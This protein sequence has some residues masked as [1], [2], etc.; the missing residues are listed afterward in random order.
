MDSTCLPSGASES[1]EA[2]WQA[3]SIHGRAAGRPARASSAAAVRS[4]MVK[5]MSMAPC[6]GSSP[7]Q[8]V[9]SGRPSSSTMTLTTGPG[10]AP[11]LRARRPGQRGGAQRVGVGEHARG[12][13][14]LAALQHHAD[15]GAVLDQHALDGALQADPR[16][17]GLGRRAQRAGHR[18]HARRGRSPRR[19]PPRPPGPGRG[20]SRRRRCPGPR[21]RPACRSGPGRRTARAPAR[22]GCPPARPRPARP[23]CPGPT[24]SSQRSRSGGSDI[25]GRAR[26][27]ARSQRSANT[28]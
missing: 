14:L 26:A 28:A 8:A 9:K 6:H 24:A 5:P 13:H 18:A 10:L 3:A 23:G 11:A 15:R 2:V 27:A 1:S 19:P 22:R 17:R 25:S 21:A 4:S 7:G 20:R 16:A 12:A